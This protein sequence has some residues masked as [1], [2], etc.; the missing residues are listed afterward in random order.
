MTRTDYARTMMNAL[1]I[2]ALLVLSM[3]GAFWADSQYNLGKL[4]Q[5][6]SRVPGI[7]VPIFLGLAAF[8][9]LAAVLTTVASPFFRS[10]KDELDEYGMFKHR[11][12]ED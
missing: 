4:L 2:L 9:I 3:G 12:R 1:F 10:K 7:V 6:P 5:I 8:V 11:E